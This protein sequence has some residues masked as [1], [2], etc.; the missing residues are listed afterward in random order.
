MKRGLAAFARRDAEEAL[1]EFRHAQNL[2]PDANMPYRYAAE[3]L[4]EL[5]RFEEAIAEYEIYLRIKPDV[6]D[7]ND[8]RTRIATIRAKLD[9]YVNLTSSP[10][11]AD[12]FVDNGTQRVGVTPIVGLR[13][14]R[15]PHRIVV[16]LRS[17]EVILTPVIAGGT[18]SSLAADFATN[19]PAPPPAVAIAPEPPAPAPKP[20]SRPLLGWILLGSGLGVVVGSVAVDVFALRPAYEDFDRKRKAGDP[21]AIDDKD[22]V[23]T[24]QDALAVTYGV[25]ALA[26]LVGGGILLFAPR[27][28]V[29]VSPQIGPDLAMARLAA[30]F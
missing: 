19:E 13:L 26:A 6:S 16:R 1:T 20:E 12:V 10:A 14:R 28:R 8:V 4:V 3:A 21:T 5:D 24:M 30:S 25:G 9:G 27:S 22:S 2:V 18:T 11:G 7:A 23:T 29:A 15:G 17:R